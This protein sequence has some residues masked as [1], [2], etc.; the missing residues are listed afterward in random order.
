MQR[1]ILG[2]LLAV[3]MLVSFVSPIF[4]E[5][6]IIILD[7]VK[8]EETKEKEVITPTEKK[9]E[10]KDDGVIVLPSRDNENNILEERKNEKQEESNKEVKKPEKKAEEKKKEKK[11]EKKEEKKEDIKELQERF[12]SED[13]EEPEELTEEEYEALKATVED[14]EE[15]GGFSFFRRVMTFNA[16]KSAP[17]KE[18]QDPV[19]K[20]SLDYLENEVEVSKTHQSL[21]WN[22]SS[23]SVKMRVNYSLDGE[24]V[25]KPGEVEITV[26]RYMYKDRDGKLIG[27]VT[28]GVPRFPNQRQPFAYI[29]KED[30]VTFINTQTLNKNTKAF[31]EMTVHGVNTFDVKDVVTGEK[32]GPMTADMTL[33]HNG[34]VLEESAEKKLTVDVDTQAKISSVYTDDGYPYEVYPDN[35]PAEFKPNNDSEYVYADFYTNVTTSAT[36]PYTMTFDAKATGFNGKILGAVFSEGSEKVKADANGTLTKSYNEP[37]KRELRNGRPVRLFV[38]YPIHQ[39]TESKVYNLPLDVKYTVT[40]IDDKKTT[41][42]T[43]NITVPYKPIRFI[44]PDNHFGAYI[45]GDGPRVIYSSGYREGV[46]GYALNALNGDKEVT[47]NY[48]SRVSAFNLPFTYPSWDPKVDNKDENLDNYKQRR[49]KTEARLGYIEDNNIKNSIDIESI[50]LTGIT[51]YDYIKYPNSGYGYFEGATGK[52]QYGYLPIGNFGYKDKSNLN[53][54]AIK[55]K[56]YTFELFGLIN[57]NYTKFA[58]IDLNSKAFNPVN[59]AEIKDG[60]LY[61]PEGVKEIKTVLDSGI[62]GYN[63]SFDMDYKVKPTSEIKAIAKHQIENFEKPSTRVRA[64]AV[65]KGITDTNQTLNAVSDSGYDRLEGLTQETTLSKNL[66]YNNDVL[67]ARVE[68]KYTTTY[69]SISNLMVKKEFDEA[70]SEN[71][72]KEE[73]TSTWYELLPEGFDLDTKSI[74]SSE[75]IESFNIEKNY[76]GTGRD[77]LVVKTINNPKYRIKNRRYETVPYGYGTEMSISYSGYYP[78]IMMRHFAIKQGKGLRYN[79]NSSSLYKSEN[80]V[81]GTIIGY[82]GIKNNDN[83]VNE[84]LKEIDGPN[85]NISYLA[86]NL[87]SDLH[88]DTAAVVGAEKTADVNNENDYRFGLDKDMFVYENGYYK[89]RMSLTASGN[90]KVGS[91]VMYD[92]LDG[93]ALKEGEDTE[94]GTKTWKGELLG[95]DFNFLDSLGVEP[96]IYYSTQDLNLDSTEWTDDMNLG[97]KK[98]WTTVKPNVKDIK[99]IAVDLTK[100]KRGNKFYIAD[101]QTALLEV[102]MKAPALTEDNKNA[103][104]FNKGVVA[105]RP[106]ISTETKKSVTPTNKTKVGIKPFYLSIYHEFNDDDNRDGI[107]PEEITLDI[108]KNGKKTN[109]GPVVLNKDDNWYKEVKGVEYQDENGNIN[110]YTLKPIKEYKDYEVVPGTPKQL[111]DRLEYNVKSTHSPYKIDVTINKKWQGSSLS[112]LKKIE[113]S[114]LNR[115]ASINVE[116]LANDKIFRTITIMPDKDNNWSYTLKDVFKNEKGQPIKYEVKELGYIEGYKP[117]EYSEDKLTII[118]KYYPF[119]DIKISKDLINATPLAKDKTHKFKIE[120]Y[121][122]DG[123][124][125]LDTYNYETDSGR[126]GTI[127]T[128]GYIE[129]NAVNKILEVLT[130]KDIPSKGKVVIS[131]TELAGFTHKTPKQE[132]KATSGRTVDVKFVSEYKT[133]GD[134]VLKGKKELK[135]RV[136][137]AFSFLFDVKENGNI[138]QSIRSDK[139]GDIYYEPIN[140]SLKDINVSTGKGIKKYELTERNET[141]PGYKYDESVINLTVSITDNGDGT[142][143]AVPEFTKNGA[144]T[145]LF[146]ENTYTAKG[147]LS[148]FFYKEIK[149]ST[150]KPQKDEFTFKIY[151]DGVLLGE[152]KNNEF[153]EINFVMKDKF[154]EKDIDKVLN[155]QVIET[156]FDSNI[157]RKNDEE[158]R[159]TLKVVD[160]GDGTLSNDVTYNGRYLGKKRVDEGET[161]PKFINERL[162]GDLKVAKLVDGNNPNPEKK[163]KFKVTFE[164]TK[165]TIPTKLEGKILEYTNKNSHNSNQGSSDNYDYDHNG[166]SSCSE[167]SKKGIHCGRN[168]ALECV[169]GRWKCVE[170]KKDDDNTMSLPNN[171]ILEVSSIRYPEMYAVRSAEKMSLRSATQI[172][173]NATNVVDRRDSDGYLA[174]SS[175]D[176]KVTTLEIT[177]D[178]KNGLIAIYNANNGETKAFRQSYKSKAGLTD[179]AFAGNKENWG[180]NGLIIKGWSLDKNAKKPDY[181]IG[182]VIKN[183]NI[184]DKRSTNADT[185]N[186]VQLYAVWGKNGFALTYNANGGKGS[187]AND[188][189]EYDTN[190]NLKANAFYKAG[191]KLA[192]WST[193]QNGQVEF[194]DKGLLNKSEAQITNDALTLYAVWEEDNLNLESDNG[195]F[196]FELRQDEEITF[197]NLPAGL[198]YKIEEIEEAPWKVVKEDNTL[199]EIEPKKES[200]AIVTN[201]YNA[202]AAQVDIEA[203]KQIDGVNSSLDD[204]TFKLE[205]SGVSYEVRAN[206]ETGKITFPTLRF[207]APGTH[208]YK[209]REIAGVNKE[210]NFDSKVYDIKVTVSEVGGEL[211][212]K[213]TGADNII[214]NNTRKKADLTVTKVTEGRSLTDDTFTFDLYVDGSLQET[215]NLKTSQS[216]TFNLPVGSRYEVV[217]KD[218]PYPWEEVKADNSGTIVEGENTVTIKNISSLGNNTSDTRN[219]VSILTKKELLG[220]DMVRGEFTFSLEILDVAKFGENE[221]EFSIYSTT[222]TNDEEGNIEFNLPVLNVN[223]GEKIRITEIKGTDESIVYDESVHT[224]T[225][226]KTSDPYKFELKDENGKT[227][228]ENTFKNK[229]QPGKLRITKEITNYRNSLKDHIFKVKVTAEGMDE[230][231]IEVKVNTPVEVELPFNSHYTVEEIDIPQGYTLD[232]YINETGIVEANE[233]KDVTIKNT[234]NANATLKFTG[235]KIMQNTMYKEDKDLLQKFNFNFMVL[236]GEGNALNTVT[237]D[238]DGNINF[239]SFNYNDTQI[240]QTFKYRIFEMNE[241]Q[242]GVIFDKTTYEIDVKVVDNGKGLELEVE[243]YKIMA[244]KKEKIENFNP[245]DITFTNTEYYVEVPET[246]TLGKLPFFG[247]FAMLILVAFVLGDKRRG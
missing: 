222:A 32:F 37:L 47:I 14:R 100:D 29:V 9:E 54:F 174:Y 11:D 212:A 165:E 107:R 109:L 21:N 228:A 221:D 95:F 94:F 10:K 3:L 91:I 152:A 192:G 206:A 39:F 180:N 90:T 2:F 27:N 120:I 96:V 179:E 121:K 135:G 160:N 127:Q 223:D 193:T 230:K 87:S 99:A 41:E 23:S 150:L 245:N 56:T 242:G 60:R 211:V 137:E 201:K 51:L 84:N 176:G 26:P 202:K 72:Y 36:Q 148:L 85:P 188:V 78:W 31:I 71:L 53:D 225:I 48:D 164:G 113:E 213:V 43:K 1:K 114:P 214:F 178:Y 196:Y 140:Y 146:F 118:N 59:G 16:L 45:D 134:I 57:G 131:E 112:I 195:V 224:Y 183:T 139:K 234:Y 70:K 147:D 129:M 67:N 50:K 204:F 106:E 246:G 133:K 74:R 208:S 5:G 175:E 217:E 220:R 239:A 66:N 115:P 144:K 63:Y 194:A 215:F 136:M 244:G 80:E 35:Y 103:F 203:Q 200:L 156:G 88:I 55:D 64:G 189:V 19:I 219:L 162:D 157:Y 110:T 83:K 68:L 232:S 65:M 46:Y 233:T 126:K 93:Y 44:A 155:L 108:Y 151:N 61:F 209:V 104:A 218:I 241:G 7:P 163:F 171:D 169:N 158:L 42:I 116:V 186:Q 238:L 181:K 237:H 86:D 197:K 22:N 123:A 236:D 12:L 231:I 190:F 199:S 89:Y 101:G 130:I 25:F 154:T 6:N 105:W 187:M 149:H 138:V 170:V 15:K 98:K 76:K 124:L 117:A 226:T 185:L 143:T 173:A 167:A 81:L 198:K 161:I 82:K 235:R 216:K 52:V 172:P 111:S 210:Y 28:Y 122:E 17:K 168:T 229:V 58:D 49:F 69:D 30:T 73:K 79:V 75:Q 20:V 132:V 153:G 4:A 191:Y 125:D 141:K 159:F 77:L 142:L 182:E 8:N 119:G 33:T 18:V 184:Y 92:K 13:L 38:A 227:P 128:G 205:G 102:K 97:D 145:T 40:G 62:P 177:N 247:M 207:L 166:S 243:G 24:D 240:G 34:K